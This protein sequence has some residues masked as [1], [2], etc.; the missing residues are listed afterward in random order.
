MSDTEPRRMGN[1]DGPGF[2][3]TG[4]RVSRPLG[5]DF[6]TPGNWCYLCGNGHTYDDPCGLLI[7]YRAFISKDIK[8]WER[9]RSLD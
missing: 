4:G 8:R 5:T 7:A 1:L 2:E 9:E 3:P 6:K